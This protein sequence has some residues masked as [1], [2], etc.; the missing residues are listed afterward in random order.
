MEQA[1]MTER[2]TDQLEQVVARACRLAGGRDGIHAVAVVGGRRLTYDELARLRP[3]AAAC[4]VDLSMD[5]LGLITLRP[6]G[7]AEPVVV[8]SATRRWP[9]SGWLAKHAMPRAVRAAQERAR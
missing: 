1:K 8:W 9:W 7:A 5:G 6:G 4:H 2:T 3:Q